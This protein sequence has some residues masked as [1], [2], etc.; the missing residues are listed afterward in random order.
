MHVHIYAG[1][2]VRETRYND[3]IVFH[4]QSAWDDAAE[5]LQGTALEP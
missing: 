4:V 2:S 5:R 3:I 1:I